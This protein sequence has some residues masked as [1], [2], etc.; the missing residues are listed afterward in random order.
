LAEAILAAGTPRGLELAGL[1]ARDSL[2][3]EAG[4]PLYGHEITADVS[5]LAAGLGWTVKLD[6]AADFIGRDALQ[7][8]KQEGSREKVVFF[9]TGDRRIIRADAPVFAADGSQV[10]RVVSGTLS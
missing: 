9:K 5:P 7:R 3:L 2:R 6:K 8:E 10:G 4:Y 1:G